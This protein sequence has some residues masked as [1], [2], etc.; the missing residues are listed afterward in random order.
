MSAYRDLDGYLAAES[1]IAQPT[2]ARRL[3]ALASYLNV[4]WP[5]FRRRCEELALAGVDD[6]AHPRSRLLS[7]RGLNTAVRY[8]A[9]ID[10]L[11]GHDLARR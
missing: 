5:W 4:P 8:V 7:T 2:S 9:Y 11:E 1:L 6:I 3:E 10:S